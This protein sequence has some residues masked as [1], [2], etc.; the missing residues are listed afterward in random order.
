MNILNNSNR[1]MAS[2]LSAGPEDIASWPSLQIDFAFELCALGCMDT[3][4]RLLLAMAIILD[5]SDLLMSIVY[6]VVKCGLSSQ[7]LPSKPSHL[8]SSSGS[9]RQT[10]N[11]HFKEISLFFDHVQ[12]N[13]ALWVQQTRAWMREMQPRNIYRRDLHF[14]RP[15]METDHQAGVRQKVAPLGMLPNARSSW[16]IHEEQHLL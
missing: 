1:L 16:S 14:V 5:G 7:L 15:R 13:I 12:S 11:C 9:S 4:K 3:H 10:K 6:C 8:P 2:E